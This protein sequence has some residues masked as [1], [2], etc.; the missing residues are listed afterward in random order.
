MI[1]VPIFVT[2]INL[3]PFQELYRKVRSILNK[4]TPQKF[5]TLTQQIID[6]DIDT[7]ERLEGAIDLI[8]EKVGTL[9]RSKLDGRGKVFILVWFMPYITDVFFSVSS[10]TCN[11]LP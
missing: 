3:F 4:L 6:L 1:L 5:Q 9:Y 10:P 8:F 11:L 2:C 7:A